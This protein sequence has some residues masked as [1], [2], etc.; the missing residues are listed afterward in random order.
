MVATPV[1][2]ASGR[3]RGKGRVFCTNQMAVD[4]SLC[5]EREREKERE[6]GTSL[7]L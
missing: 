5:F 4:L 2:A 1:A 7:Y 6:R 3:R